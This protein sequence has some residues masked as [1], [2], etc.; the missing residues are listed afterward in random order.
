MNTSGTSS[1]PRSLER[2]EVFTLE[3]FLGSVDHAVSKRHLARL[4][5]VRSVTRSWSGK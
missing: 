5:L 2:D 1:T 4:P 3:G